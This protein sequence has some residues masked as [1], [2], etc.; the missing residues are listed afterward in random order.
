MVQCAYKAD[1]KTKWS[2]ALLAIAAGIRCWRRGV[3]L[4]DHCVPSA[5]AT[6][7]PSVDKFAD[8][9]HFFLWTME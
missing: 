9:R 4:R 1:H 6:E 2:S 8:R 5:S 7:S 3:V